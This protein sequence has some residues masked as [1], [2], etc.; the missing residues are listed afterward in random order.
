MKTLFVK[1]LLY[2]ID[3]ESPNRY[4]KPVVQGLNIHFHDEKWDENII[5]KMPIFIWLVNLFFVLEIKQLWDISEEELA[6][7]NFP[8]CHS[9]EAIGFMKYSEYLQNNGV[10]RVAHLAKDWSAKYDADEF[11]FWGYNPWV[12]VLKLK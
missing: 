1:P 6:V 3:L 8:S 11:L 4:S 10:S 2:G 7:N 12:F 9:S 5:F